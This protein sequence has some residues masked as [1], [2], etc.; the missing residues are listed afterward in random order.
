MGSETSDEFIDDGWSGGLDFKSFVDWTG[1][2]V[3]ADSE[4]NLWLLLHGKFFAQ[5]IYQNFRGFTAVATV[6]GFKGSSWG[7]EGEELLEI[8]DSAERLKGCNLGLDWSCAGVDLIEFVELENGVS[9]WIFEKNK[10]N[11][12]FRI[13]ESNDLL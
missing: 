5:E 3:V 2:F 13:V 7:L 6:N 10:K 8:S 4:F 12:C 9:D 1:K 11:H